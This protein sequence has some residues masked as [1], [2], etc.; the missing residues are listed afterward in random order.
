[1]IS[2]PGETRVLRPADVILRIVTHVFN[3][4]GQILA[5]C[6]TLGKPNESVD[7]DYPVDAVFPR[8]NP[9]GKDSSSVL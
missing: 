5:M 3:H 4:E 7:L 6:R 8:A 9:S 2:D 1:M